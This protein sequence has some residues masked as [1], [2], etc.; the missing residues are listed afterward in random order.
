MKFF[1]NFIEWRKKEDVDNI[2]TNFIYTELLELKKVFPHGYHKTD[3]WGR[4]I[5]YQMI[6]KINIDEILKVT[7]QERLIKHLIQEYEQVMRYKLKACSKVK[8]EL[9]EQYTIILDVEG[10]GISHL[11]GQSK[12]FN[13]SI[14][15][16][17]VFSL[18]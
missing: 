4:P 3:K 13:K 8:G 5:Y 17:I 7:T 16:I 6:S 10:I 11:F 1:R 2:E 14:S 18:F 15:L 12:D 9:I